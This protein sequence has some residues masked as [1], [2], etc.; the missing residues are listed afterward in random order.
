MKLT[1]TLVNLVGIA[2]LLLGNSTVIQAQIPGVPS[3]PGIPS[4]SDIPGQ[5]GNIMDQALLLQKLQSQGYT[6][7]QDLIMNDSNLMETSALD[8]N[9]NLVKLLINPMTGDIIKSQLLN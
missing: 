1:K 6:D 9:G 7:I 4:T 2:G 8:I 5:T 3:T